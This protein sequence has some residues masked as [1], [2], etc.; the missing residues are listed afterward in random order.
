MLQSAKTFYGHIFEGVSST[1]GIFGPC[2][3]LENKLS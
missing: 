2:R 3:L 1:M